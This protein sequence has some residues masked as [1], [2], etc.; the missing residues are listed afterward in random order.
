MLALHAL[1]S[2]AAKAFLETMRKAEALV[3]RIDSDEA[4]GAAGS[5]RA[6]APT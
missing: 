3:P 6:I 5:S 2:D 4:Q 1:E